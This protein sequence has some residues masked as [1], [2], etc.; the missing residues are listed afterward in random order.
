MR[1]A[2]TALARPVAAAVPAAWIIHSVA[3]RPILLVTI[4]GA[5]YFAAYAALSYGSLG[6]EPPATPSPLPASRSLARV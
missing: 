1:I 5:A 2:P 3:L 6:G 4:T